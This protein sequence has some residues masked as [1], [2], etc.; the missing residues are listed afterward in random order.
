[1]KQKKAEEEKQKRLQDSM[2]A[3]ESWREN[4]K[5]KPRPATQGLLR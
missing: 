1:M 3:Y 5:N 2:K 4:A